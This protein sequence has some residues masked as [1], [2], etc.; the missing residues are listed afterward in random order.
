MPAST[1][2]KAAQICHHS[3]ESLYFVYLLFN[4]YGLCPMGAT[5]GIL[6]ILV[7]PRSYFFL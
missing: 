4:S 5:F 1:I 7:T 3:T 6:V 2:M